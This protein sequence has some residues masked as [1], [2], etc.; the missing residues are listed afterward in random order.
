MSRGLARTAL[1]LVLFVLLAAMLVVA[2]VGARHRSQLSHCRNNLRELGRLGLQLM[3]NTE[4]EVLATKRGGGFWL[5]CRELEMDD[6]GDIRER[7]VDPYRCPLI[8]TPGGARPPTAIVDYRGPAKDP[9]ANTRE[10]PF[11][12]D[13]PLNHGEGGVVNLL[14][15]D[16]SVLENPGEGSGVTADEKPGETPL[17]TVLE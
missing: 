14:Y 10:E 4:K 17:P 8:A 9:S 1:I 6:R 16:L 11:G 3:R 15:L 2:A 5:A 7:L 13:R 12:A